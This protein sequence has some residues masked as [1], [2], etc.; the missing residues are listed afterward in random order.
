MNA[1]ECD[2]IEQIKKMQEIANRIHQEDKEINEFFTT[3]KVY[4]LERATK[5]IDKFAI[6]NDLNVYIL[7]LAIYSNIAANY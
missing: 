7:L 6:K 2:L 4:L 5:Y 3:D 1:N